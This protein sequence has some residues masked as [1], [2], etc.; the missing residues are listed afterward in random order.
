[1]RFENQLEYLMQ[2][3]NSELEVPQTQAKKR[4]YGIIKTAEIGDP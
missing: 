2:F 4:F 1:M 3:F